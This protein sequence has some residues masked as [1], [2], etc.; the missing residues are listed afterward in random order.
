MGLGHGV[1]E[2]DELIDGDVPKFGEG[3]AE[4]L[5]VE[6]IGLE[7]GAF[8]FGAG[9]V[10]AVAGEEDADVHLI[11]LGFE[12][13][14]EALDAVPAAFVPEG[15]A[16]FEGGAFG[17]LLALAVLDPALLVWLEFVPRGRG[18][19]A[20]FGAKAEEVALAFF[21]AFALE[22]FDGAFGEGEEVV[23]DG[24]VEV[25]ADDAAEASAVI[26]GAEGGIEGEEGGGGF[27]EGV[28]GGGEIT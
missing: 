1:E 20:D 16:L 18:V 25:D 8:A 28:P 17:G 10:G 23:G 24:F 9:G 15:F 3:F 14:E 6:G 12:P 2:E 19:D 4:D 7:A 22:G 13:V 26:T 5:E 27:D 21:A 11:G